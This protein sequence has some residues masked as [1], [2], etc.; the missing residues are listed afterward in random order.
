MRA[1]SNPRSNFNARSNEVLGADQH[2][3]LQGL[4]VREFGRAVSILGA[5]E[6]KVI[7]QPDGD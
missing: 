4:I 5:N 7:S 2:S 1:L 6:I 3:E